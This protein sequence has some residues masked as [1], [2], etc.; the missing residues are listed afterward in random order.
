ML[1]GENSEK[2]TRHYVIDISGSGM[3]YEVGDSL[4]IFPTNC[5][6]LVSDTLE[7]LGASGD[8]MV[9]SEKTG[10]PTQFRQ[11]LLSEIHLTQPSNKLLKAVAECS[12]RSE[13]LASLLK[14]DRRSDLSAYLWGREVIDI[15]LDYGDARFSPEEFVQLSKKL[16][17][18]LYSIASSQKQNPNEVHL[19]VGIVRYQAFGRQRKG[20]CTTFLAE[21][22]DE[23]TPVPVFVQPG[24]T[25]RLP[26]DLSTPIIMVGPG[27]G[28]APFRAFLQERKATGA[29]GKNW[30]FFGEQHQA[31]DFFYQ[32]ELEEYLEDGLLTR[33]DTA[34]SRDQAYKIYVQDRVLENAVE[35]W[36]W[37]EEGAHFFVCGDASRMA[38]DV[39]ITLHRAIESAG[40]LSE[41]DAAKYVATMR[42]EK[43]YKRDV[44]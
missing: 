16:A 31:S 32:N 27:T 36:K 26:E 34:F 41:A 43:R 3:T 7:A 15:L 1:T 21:R 23:R 17:P 4:A 9:T 37:L 12:Q 44:Y 22:T 19:T 40:G 2:D 10:Q 25:F 11:A 6:E 20:V 24:K 8:E 39:D 42:K 30:L 28:V 14:P 18:R 29:P 33:L 5:P 35:L 13:E 38:K